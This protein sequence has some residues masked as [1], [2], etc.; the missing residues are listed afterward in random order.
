MVAGRGAPDQAHRDSWQRGGTIDC[1]VSCIPRAGGYRSISVVVI[2][3]IRKQ[4]LRALRFDLGH[5]YS[6]LLKVGAEGPE[7]FEPSVKSVWNLAPLE[8]NVSSWLVVERAV[9]C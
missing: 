3:D 7:C 6:L 1:D 4:T 8:E 2:R 5:G 9:S